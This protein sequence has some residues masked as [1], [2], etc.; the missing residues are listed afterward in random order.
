[1]GTKRNKRT[2]SRRHAS[3]RWIA[4]RLE[5]RRLLAGF[6]AIHNSSIPA[7]VN[8][9]GDVT[10]QDAFAVVQGI[11]RQYQP[12]GAAAINAEGEAGDSLMPDVNGDGQ[13]SLQDAL[14]V[15]RTINAEGE[16]TAVLI[17][18]VT[19]NEKGDGDEG[20]NDD[21]DGKAT[22][23]ISLDGMNAAADVVLRLTTTG[24]TATP[25]TAGALVS[26]DDF[27]AKTADVTIPAG[28]NS[29][30]FDVDVLTDGLNNPINES[31]ET[32][33]VSVAQVIDAG[34]MMLDTTDTGTGTIQDGRGIYVKYSID[35]FADDRTTEVSTVNAGESFYIRFSTQDVRNQLPFADDFNLDNDEWGVGGANIDISYDPT[36][37]QVNAGSS[38]DNAGGA[39][40]DFDANYQI[41]GFP[42]PFFPYGETLISGRITDAAEIDVPY[43][44]GTPSS[45]EGVI[46]DLQGSRLSQIGPDKQF[47][48]DVGITAK[49]VNADDEQ[50][51]IQENDEMGGD[52]THTIN[53]LAGDSLKSG[54]LSFTGSFSEL[55]TILVLDSTVGMG[56]N[57]ATVGSAEM[58][59]TNGS[60]NVPLP[61]NATLTLEDVTVVQSVPANLNHQASIVNGA[62]QFIAAPGFSGEVTLEY[63]VSNGIAV[64]QTGHSTDTGTV[65]I[66]VEA[67]NEAP[68]AV[69]DPAGGSV[70]ADTVLANIPVGSND[71]DPEGDAFSVI[72]TSG[73]AGVVLT[74][75][76]SNQ[77]ITI[78]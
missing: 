14:Q 76:G 75:A 44:V 60:V 24:V 56:Q 49:G 48:V 34:G 3:R 7:D 1:M 27:V 69:D 74:A 20:V 33:T 2:R 58:E 39:D 18:D 36:L 47:V 15:V 63:T 67:I 73:T 59:F 40:L 41:P 62:V 9:D 13:V 72:G 52:D 16:A 78:D 19:V 4:E 55:D 61:A 57:D 8:G 5:D 70:N 66:T 50:L 29:V 6:E 32:F 45:G 21:G 77:A 38:N 17:S 65:T 31:D 51:T 35:T 46:N 22:F 42:F 68:D 23:T 37:G 30:T 12:S 11:H 53:V 54:V 26:G 64:G 28:S 10:L 71:S 25:G 43:V